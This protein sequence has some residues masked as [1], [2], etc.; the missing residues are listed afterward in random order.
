MTG[1]FDAQTD[2]SG[3]L[4]L[5]EFKHLWKKIKEWQVGWLQPRPV[6]A[7]AQHVFV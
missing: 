2:V 3:K 5:Q 1:A 4:N 7:H 6:S